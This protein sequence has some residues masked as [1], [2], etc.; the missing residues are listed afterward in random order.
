M[1]DIYLSNAVLPVICG[2]NWLTAA[3]PFIHADRVVDFNVI[4]YVTEGCIYVTEEHDDSETDYEIHS[5]ELLFL[6]SGVRHYGKHPCPKGTSWFFA[7]FILSGQESLPLYNANEPPVQYSEQIYSAPLPKYISVP[8]DSEAVQKMEALTEQFH[9]GGRLGKWRLNSTLFELLTLLCFPDT[10]R[11]LSTADK[12]AEYLRR[13]IC[14]K[15]SA[16]HTAA[17]MHI[18][19]KRLA[20]IFR[21]EKGCTL[22]Q[23]HE[24]LRMEQA[25][26]LLRTT[27]MSVGEISDKLGFEDML[28]FSRRFRMHTKTSPTEYRR[29]GLGDYLIGR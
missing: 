22:Q 26:R 1:N 24:R 9:N 4:I 14:E 21:N 19:Y 2:C 29:Q 8:S 10:D 12:A 18:S 23:Y 3:E 27:L 5:G 17:A 11:P 13:H 7:H 15:F 6:K 28:Y 25:C 20:A 16:E